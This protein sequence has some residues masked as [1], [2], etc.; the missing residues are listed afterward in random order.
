LQAVFSAEKPAQ[1][2]NFCHFS[3][4]NQLLKQMFE[5]WLSS[6]R[7]IKHTPQHNILCQ[8]VRFPHFV[9]KIQT[10]PKKFHQIIRHFS[11]I[12]RITVD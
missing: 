12:F 2:A 6:L 7:K 10:P 9:R 11:Q 3:P 8:G 4:K 5:G 1:A